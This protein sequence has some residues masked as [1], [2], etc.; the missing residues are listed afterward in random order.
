MKTYELINFG[1]GILRDNKILSSRIDSEIILSHI[2]GVPREKLL[3]DEQ[4][5]KLD[6]IK[7]F[8][9]LILRRAKSEPIAYITK[10]KE[11]RS[12]SF[13]VDKNSLIPRPETELIIDPIVSIFRRKKLFFLDV[14]IGNGCI[15]F[16]ILKEL[17]HSSGIGIDK[18]KK[19]ILN[20]KKNLI[21][22]KLQNRTKLL[23]RPICKVFGYKFDLIVSNPPYIIKRNIKRLSKDIT[24]YEPRSALDGGNDGLDV[25]RK[26][27][28]KSRKILK[29]NGILAL[30][31][32]TGQH[33]N[34]IKILSENKFRLIETVRDYKNNIRCIY[35]TL[36]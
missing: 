23:H 7:Q 26:V 3:I 18:C 27:I 17:K 35:S 15:I 14:G 36:L 8:K 2:M 11:F 16:S 31:V 13:F 30:E 34:V 1:S 4:D 9:S 32:G 22:L 5:I 6:K 21:S 20:A 33:G 12:T 28:Y 29:S 10:V 19:T 25:I 24:K